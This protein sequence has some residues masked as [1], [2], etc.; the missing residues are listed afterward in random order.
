MKTLIFISASLT[1]KPSKLPHSYFEAKPKK[2]DAEAPFKLKPVKF[3]V[4]PHQPPDKRLLTQLAH[5]LFFMVRSWIARLN[6]AGSHLKT[7]ADGDIKP[8]ARLRSYKM[9]V[10]IA[11][12][13][14]AIVS[15]EVLFRQF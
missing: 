6:S 11:R 5:Q 14:F 12:A 15:P 1:A 3:S 10:L 9:Q 13:V 7:L 8:V 4:L 2:K